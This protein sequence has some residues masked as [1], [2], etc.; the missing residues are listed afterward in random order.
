MDDFDCSTIVEGSRSQV[1]RSWV[2]QEDAG[3][4]IGVEFMVFL[5]R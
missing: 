2:C 3:R 4:S 5:G 1:P